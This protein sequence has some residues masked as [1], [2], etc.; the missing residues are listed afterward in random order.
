M[1][2]DLEITKFQG[3][4]TKITNFSYTPIFSITEA[5]KPVRV[6]RIHEAMAAYD[7]GY[8]DRV[9]QATYEA[10]EYALKRIQARISGD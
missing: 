8:I 10:M 9:S 2:L 3:G 1:V 7:Q 5:E 6:V 4:E